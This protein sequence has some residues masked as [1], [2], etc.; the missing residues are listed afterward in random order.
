MELLQP[1]CKHKLSFEIPRRC[2]GRITYNAFS[3]EMFD[4]L[5]SITDWIQDISR[6]S[7]C[8]RVYCYENNIT[9]NVKCLECDNNTKFSGKY[10]E[11]CSKTCSNRSTKNKEARIQGTVQNY[12]ESSTDGEEFGLSFK[13]PRL[14]DGRIFSNAFSNDMFKELCSLTSFVRATKNTIRERVY[15]LANK[16]T[17]IPKCPECG[18]NVKWLEG[19]GMYAGFCCVLCS[20]NSESTRNLI[21]KTYKQR[22]GF[23][24]PSKNPCVVKKKRQKYFVKTGYF[25]HWQNPIVQFNYKATNLAK[26]GFENA[27]QSPKIRDKMSIS[28]ADHFQARRNTEGTDYKGVVYILHFPEHNA[29]KIGLSGDFEQRSKGLIKDFGDF[30]IVKLIET[31]S[32][33]KLEQE[34]HEKFKTHRICLCTGAGR[35]EFFNDCILKSEL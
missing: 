31:D 8:E 4:E 22:T 30:S 10:N 7:L 18:N 9:G 13:I 25:H 28:L 20:V 17:E 24:H 12:S 34:L 2:D 23:S 16:L 32:C 11:H 19:R 26:Y 1:I 35:T 29:V 6:K 14:D 5:C 3:D 21:T 33:F 27:A 15:C